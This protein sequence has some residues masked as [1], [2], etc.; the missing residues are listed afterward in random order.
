MCSGITANAQI[1]P[2]TEYQNEE[3]NIRVFIYDPVSREVG[4]FFKSKTIEVIHLDFY[5]PSTGQIH[6]DN[7]SDCKYTYDGR[8]EKSSRIY[9]YRDGDYYLKVNQPLG[10]NYI[11]IYTNIVYPKQEIKLFKV[12]VKQEMHW[13]D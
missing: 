6:F 2:S 4:N 10:Y 13:Y 12:N 5:G 1:T 9:T 8:G 3:Y 7:Y 11:T